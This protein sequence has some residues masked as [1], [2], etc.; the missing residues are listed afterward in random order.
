MQNTECR[1]GRVARSAVL[2]KPNFANSL[3]FNF[4][5]QEFVQ[6]GPIMIA[7][8]CNGLSFLIFEEKWPNYVFETK[9]ALNSDSFGMRLLFNVCV[10]VFCATNSTIFECL[11]TR[12]DQNELH[13]KKWFFFAE[14][15]PASSVSRSQAYLA[16]TFRSAEEE[17]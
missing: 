1:F 2:L 12:Q 11:L 10:R 4:C 16:R 13:Q 9:P 5:Q 6:Q 7:I 15:L 17:N 3:V 14:I 8:D